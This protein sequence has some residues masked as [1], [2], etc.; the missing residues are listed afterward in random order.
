MLLSKHGKARACT[1]KQAA[2]LADMAKRVHA[3]RSRLAHLLD[4]R[5]ELAQGL[6]VRQDREA[7]VLQ[8]GA[9]PDAEEAHQHG[10]VLLK[11]LL[12]EVRVHAARACGHALARE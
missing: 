6:A 7:A 5:R 11:R 8:E 4:V 2:E 12:P 3:R 10:D 9:V 1:P